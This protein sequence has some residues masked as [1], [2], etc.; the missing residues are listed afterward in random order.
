MITSIVNH[1]TWVKNDKSRYISTCLLISLKLCD[2][3]DPSPW[4]LTALGTSS[5]MNNY[6]EQ[7]GLLNHKDFKISLEI[8]IFNKVYEVHKSIPLRV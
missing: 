8:V 1:V 6:P 3:L 4:T 5:I 7:V 2:T